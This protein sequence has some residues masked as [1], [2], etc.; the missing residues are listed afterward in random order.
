MAKL[1]SL[2]ELETLR[3]SIIDKNVSIP[4]GTEIGFDPDQDR[5][6]GFKVSENGIVVV[7]KGYQFDKI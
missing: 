2:G 3:K 6:S 4:P 1:K 7:P 5:K